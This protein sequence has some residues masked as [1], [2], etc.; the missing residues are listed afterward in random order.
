MQSLSKELLQEVLGSDRNENSPLLCICL[1]DQA[2]KLG[3]SSSQPHT[4]LHFS[5]S[6]YFFS[7]NHVEE[8]QSLILAGI[9]H[10]NIVLRKRNVFFYYITACFS[11]ANRACP[12]ALCT[13]EKWH[14]ASN[15]AQV[16]LILAGQKTH[17]MYF[18]AGHQPL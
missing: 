17:L 2:P 6:L 1:D 3:L 12:G 13:G 15:T 10:K 8:L 18:I 9:T 5:S 11:A 16:V 7:G 14:C 4:E